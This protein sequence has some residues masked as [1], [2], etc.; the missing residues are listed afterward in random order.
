MAT[1][2]QQTGLLVLPVFFLAAVISAP[3]AGFLG[4]WAILIGIPVMAVILLLINRAVQPERFD[5]FTMAIVLLVVEAGGLV[6]L[7]V[8]VARTQAADIGWWLPVLEAA[9]LAAALRWAV[10]TR[11]KRR[12]QGK[13]L[14]FDDVTLGESRK[15]R[16]LGKAAVG[17]ADR[18]LAGQPVLDRTAAVQD[19]RRRLKRQPEL[20]PVVARVISERT[21]VQGWIPDDDHRTQGLAIELINE[22]GASRSLR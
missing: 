2:Y 22:A 20:G 10:R 11:R 3:F 8:K 5:L 17:H 4:A 1:Q 21:Q 19:L 14:T 7:L 6:A 18:L 16:A 15:V 13:N 9:A 12:R